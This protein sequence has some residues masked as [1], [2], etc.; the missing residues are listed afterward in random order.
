[1]LQPSVLRSLF[2]HS[3]GQDGN[4]AGR[5]ASSKHKC[6]LSSLS[7][8]CKSLQ[9]VGSVKY[10]GIT[11]MSS[12]VFRVDLNQVR[13]KFFGCTNSMLVHSAGVS[14]LIKLHLMESYCYPV[15]SYGLECFNLSSSSINHVYVHW[16]S[17]YR[18]IFDFRSPA[19]KYHQ[20]NTSS[21][22]CPPGT[23]V[24]GGLKTR[25]QTFFFTFFFLR[26]MFNYDACCFDRRPYNRVIPRLHDEARRARS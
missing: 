12:K 25:M 16:N 13:H 24:P 5:R 20:R 7:L 15:L 14:E 10:L 8:S 21:K 18:K 4:F 17:V 9:L 11:F 22:T 23:T 19:T 26:R 6:R 1:M 3:V 2:S